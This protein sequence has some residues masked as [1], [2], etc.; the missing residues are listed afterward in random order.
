MSG[1][2]AAF[3]DPV[4][5][6]ASHANIFDKRHRLISEVSHVVASF[7][8]MLASVA[9]WHHGVASSV[10]IVANLQGGLLNLSASP[11]PSPQVLAGRISFFDFSVFLF[12][13]AFSFLFFSSV[14]FFAFPLWSLLFSVKI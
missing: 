3:F 12:S 1:V 13:S 8:S 5:P 11:P 14:F 10:H 2:F 4:L 7:I 6:T 9:S